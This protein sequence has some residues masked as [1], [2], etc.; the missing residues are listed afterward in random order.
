MYFDIRAEC[1]SK[2]HT[3]ASATER[4]S[5]E[6]SSAEIVFVLQNIIYV[7]IMKSRENAHIY[8][9]KAFQLNQH[10]KTYGQYKQNLDLKNHNKV[11]KKV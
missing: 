8:S 3:A 5:N 9:I 10:R 1:G 11:Y 7:Y 6:F 2:I 4:P